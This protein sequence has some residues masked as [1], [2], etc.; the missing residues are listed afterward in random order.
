MLVI[1]LV[2][3]LVLSYIFL[4]AVIHQLALPQID[5]LK[6]KK[7]DKKLTIL[8]L[9]PHPDDE[10]MNIGGTLAYY[11]GRGDTQVTVVSTTRGE[12]GETHGV[13]A[14]S[15]LGAVRSDELVGAM[16]CLGVHDVR[17]FDFPDGQMDKHIAELATAMAALLQELQPQVVITYDRS[18]LYGHPDH[19]VLSQVITRLI[20]QQFPEIKLLYATL[21]HKILKR[22]GLPIEID[23]Y[24]KRVSMR[25]GKLRHTLPTYKATVWRQMPAKL[26]AIRTYRSQDLLSTLPLPLWLY[27]MLMG[28]EYFSDGNLPSDSRR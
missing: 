1:I 26:H 17:L 10:T 16:A 8:S 25:T 11:A 27:G 9:F 22:A 24:G 2:I 3:S 7:S 18:G 28:F 5:L 19:I 4:L 14:V 13:C 12:A 15:E 20:R 6:Y 21:P 23:L